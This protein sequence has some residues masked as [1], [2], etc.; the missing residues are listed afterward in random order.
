MKRSWSALIIA[1]MAASWWWAPYLQNIYV[2]LSLFIR[3]TWLQMRPNLTTCYFN[4][5][6]PMGDRIH[7]K[8][9]D[10]CLKCIAMKFCEGPHT[11]T[12]DNS[13]LMGKRPPRRRGRMLMDTKL[14]KIR[15]ET[16]RKHIAI[17]VNYA[18]YAAISYLK[19]C[20]L[21]CLHLFLESDVR[22]WT[23]IVDA[24]VYDVNS[25][26]RYHRWCVYWNSAINLK[27]I[28]W[29]IISSHQDSLS[30]L[31]LSL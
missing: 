1:M 20:N 12:D 21:N 27:Q 24:G 3:F 8:G 28:V 22:H 5:W 16:F 4:A 17:D 29:S 19:F 9:A 26:S 18:Q 2:H 23:S 14:A 13:V 25:A 6:C 15:D 10:P 7:D 11:C 30:T 31:L